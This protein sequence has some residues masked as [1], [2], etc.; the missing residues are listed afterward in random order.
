MGKKDKQRKKLRNFTKAKVKQVQEDQEP[1]VPD[2]PE[3]DGTESFVQTL[4]ETSQLTK[5]DDENSVLL[6]I[7]DEL[8]QDPS[9]ELPGFIAAEIEEGEQEYEETRSGHYGAIESRRISSKG[10]ELSTARLKI[11]MLSMYLGIFL[12]ALDNTIVSTLLAHIASEFNELPRIS[13]VATAY[14]LSSATFQPI[15]GKISDIFGRKVVLIFCNITF[16]VGSLICGLSPSFEWLVAGRFIAGIG[17][18][19]ITSMSS[20][21]TSDI[22]PLRNRA[23]YQG[24]CNFY[25]GLGTA[26]GGVVGGWFSDRSVGWRMSFLIQL[27]IAF[28]STILII[29]FLRLPK[30]SKGRGLQVDGNYFSTIKVRLSAVDWIGATTLVLFLFSFMITASLGGKEIPYTSH[31]FIG[32]CVVTVIGALIFGY[33]ELK[34]A[35]DPILPLRFLKDRSVL[36]SSLSNWFCMMALMTVSYYLPIYFAGVLNMKPTDIGKRII[37]NFFSTAFGSLGAGYY[38]KKTGKYYWFVISFCVLASIGCLQIVW[39]QPDISVFKQYTLMFIPGLGASVLITVALL[40]MIAAVPHNHQAVT[41]SISYAFRSTG[42]TLGV[43]IGG[44]I[45]RES[46]DNLLKSKVLKFKSPE[47]SEDELMRIID[48]ASQS[49][50][51]VQNSSPSFIKQTL[52]DCYHFACKNV[53]IFCLLCTIAATFSMAIIKEHRLH[54]TL[55]RD[56]ENEE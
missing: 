41:T 23:L 32:L 9:T 52:I 25:F 54:N 26:L 24:I 44:A 2:P 3:F 42:C 10:T 53:F 22:V 8:L 4:A 47:H 50:E 18:G 39:I 29:L 7:R 6:P 5:E 11:I 12:A 55:D 21:T 15:Y 43:S 46:L 1:M 37:P 34:I 28:F 19:G 49:T 48:K 40:A 16:F 20:I 13:W 30:E 56:N 38:M 36:G 33:T 51:W 31:K 17:G 45:F 27:P 35:K 14:L